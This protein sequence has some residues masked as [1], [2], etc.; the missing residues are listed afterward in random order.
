M[1]GCSPRPL[2]IK[3]L[4]IFFYILPPIFWLAEDIFVRVQKGIFSWDKPVVW[5]H[6]LSLLGIV[7]PGALAFLMR[8]LL[9]ITPL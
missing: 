6:P 7:V 8:V 4:A 3:L 1:E 5:E 9:F 2:T